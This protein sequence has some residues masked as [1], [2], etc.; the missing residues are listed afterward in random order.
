ME[1]YLFYREVYDI[2]KEIPEGRVVTY[3]QIAYLM[4][5]P[6]CSRMVGQALFHVPEDLSLP[7]HRVVNSC[8]RLVPTW[9][10]QR[11][12]LEA[13]GVS[14]KKNGCVDLKKSR[15]DIDEEWRKF[16]DFCSFV[17]ELVTE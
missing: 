13:E 1:R 7:C 12:L 3:G 15:W 16:H 17:C 10:E 6:L 4:G 2:V 8:G 9:F 14:F 5:K 11:S